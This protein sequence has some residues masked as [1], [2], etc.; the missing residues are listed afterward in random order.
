MGTILKMNG[1]ILL[2]GGGDSKQSN[3]IDEYLRNTIIPV[4]SSRCLYIPLALK[5][6]F[7]LDGLR[8]FT[9]QYNYLNQVDM[10]TN[11]SEALN[12]M[13]NSYDL[14]YI[15][16]GNTGKLL[17]EITLYHLD[18]FI[19]DHIKSGG[20]VYGGSAGAIIFGKTITVAPKD[21]FES[22]KDNHGLNLLGNNSIVPHFNGTFSQH[23][24][25]EAKKY[26]SGLIGISE[27]SG[28]VFRDGE[29]IKKINSRGI[30]QFTKN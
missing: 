14:I 10:V 19:L 20:V 1:L 27:S 2:S 29:V 3:R 11:K 24:I 28:L 21:E 7:Y 13:K 16:G 9:D 8:W 6:D 25:K 18:Q 4:D 12:Y 30:D 17:Y 22:T 5:N 23:H 15:G 26:N